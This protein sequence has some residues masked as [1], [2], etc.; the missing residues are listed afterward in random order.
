MFAKTNHKTTEFYFRAYV[1]MNYNN[2]SGSYLV[3]RD[4]A[5][6]IGLVMN[7]KKMRD[8][9]FTWVCT[10]T[11]ML[12]HIMSQQQKDSISFYVKG[13]GRVKP[14]GKS[15]DHTKVP[16]PTDWCSPI[17]GKT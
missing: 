3:S 13:R 8:V 12:S 2:G 4:V 1:L 7:I 15:R 9:S 10:K 17:S 16:R 14:F 6:R 5:H 11:P